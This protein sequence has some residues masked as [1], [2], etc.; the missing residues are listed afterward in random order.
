MRGLYY[1]GVVAAG[2]T[3]VC[4]VLLV[5][6]LVGRGQFGGLLWPGL[7]ILAW[8]A[9]RAWALGVLGL[10]LLQRAH[11]WVGAALGALNV[12]VG[13][14]A[15]LIFAEDFYGFFGFVRST[16]NQLVRWADAAD[17]I[18]LMLLAVGCMRPGL[19][20]PLGL[21]AFG[22]S[23]ALVVAVYGLQE[24]VGPIPF[25]ILTPDLLWAVQLL[26]HAVAFAVLALLLWPRKTGA[27]AAGEPAPGDSASS[28]P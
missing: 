11:D 28:A 19:P 18:A 21:R 24:V 20:Q 27:D 4:D 7:F 6:D 22:V 10:W 2:L 9:L 8:L 3:V 13:V 25:F 26:L 17:N 12:L 23:L 14:V 1:S 15:L 5:L 16:L